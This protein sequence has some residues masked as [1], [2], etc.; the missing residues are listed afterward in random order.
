MLTSLA[1]IFVFGWLAKIICE[2]IGI[3]SLV[4]MMIVGMMISPYALDWLSDSLLNIAA[5]LRQLALII[6]LTRAGLSL[7]LDDLKQIGRPA[8]LMCFVP[9]CFE[10]LGVLMFACML[11][12]IS[13]QEAA[14]VGSVLA[15]VS[16]AVI[17]PRMLKLM[18]QGYGV[19]HKIPQLILAG[20][21][22][23]DVFV[24]ILFTAFTS[25]ITQNT[26]HASD[27]MAIPISII[28]GIIV[29]ILVGKVMLWLF[30]CMPMHPSM[31]TI[32]L[33]SVSFLLLEVEKQ[34]SIPMSALLSIMSMGMMMGKEKQTKMVSIQ[35]SYNR[36]WIAAEILL[37]V[38]V[39]ASV[40]VLYAL[41]AGW[42]LILLVLLALCIRMIGVLCC[43]IKTDLT[44]KERCF[45]MIA[46][47]PKAT[48]QAAIGGIP[49][50]MGLACGNQVLAAAVV[51]ILITAPIG[52]FLIDRFHPILLEKM[53]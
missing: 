7:K 6:I 20:A 46:Y 27:L 50:S 5:D 51:A 15:A 43:F 3:P 4:G 40:D 31:N 11:L 25:L 39:G 34:I 32:L 35:E 41:Q 12:S 24:I 28:V 45:C 30:E 2:K 22:V 37:F 17:V 53:K 16:P 19:K 29:G 42:S 8:L 18:E 23:D 14:L 9:A 38:L 49:L 44:W 52:A 33:L 10:I 48:V 47:S 21:S 13:L 26:F 1:I 36:L